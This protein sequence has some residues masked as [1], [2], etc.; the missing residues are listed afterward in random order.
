MIRDRL[1]VFRLKRPISEGQNLLVQKNKTYGENVS[2]AII[3]KK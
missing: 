1:D 2:K 3:R